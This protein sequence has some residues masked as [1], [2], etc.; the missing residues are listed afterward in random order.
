MKEEGFESTAHSNQ[1]IEIKPSKIKYQSLLSAQ[2]S[3]CHLQ[4]TAFFVLMTGIVTQISR[5]I[6]G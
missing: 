4:A 1:P 2:T 5:P 3:S 6:E